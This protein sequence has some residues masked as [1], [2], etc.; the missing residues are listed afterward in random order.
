QSQIHNLPVEDLRSVLNLQ[1]GVVESGK[2]KGVSIRGGRPGEA[3]V[4]VDGV[5]VR[6]TQ[7]G[8]TPLEVGTNAVEAASV[9]TGA[10]GADFGDAQSGVL[11]FVTRARG[12]PS[13]RAR[14]IE[15][16]NLG[17]PGRNDGY[18]RAHGS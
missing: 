14:A 16:D 10:I 15:T 7:R 1:P 12:P 18:D 6:N 9:T 5:L 3:A 13:S 17:A 8:F 11:S 2:Q 4:F